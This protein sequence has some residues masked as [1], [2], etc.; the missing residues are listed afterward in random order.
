MVSR[1]EKSP[2]RLSESA[3]TR[4]LLR[5][6][7]AVARMKGGHWLGSADGEGERESVL[8]PYLEPFLSAFPWEWPNSSGGKPVT[9]A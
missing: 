3:Y 2:S 7:I 6:S 8:H 1:R 9:S 4:L 5:L